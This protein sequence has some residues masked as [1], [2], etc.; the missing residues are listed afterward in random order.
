MQADA[1]EYLERVNPVT[2]MAAAPQFD[3]IHASPH[4]QRYSPLT[5]RWARR[6]HPDLVAPVR[7]LLQTAGLP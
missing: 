3:A 6:L 2:G 4:C 1:L 7:E 5:G